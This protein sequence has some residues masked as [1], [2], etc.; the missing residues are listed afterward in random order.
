MS[1]VNGVDDGVGYGVSGRS[2]R[3]SGVGVYGDSS[4]GDGV[5]GWSSSGDGVRGYSYNRSG[6]IGYSYG[7]GVAGFSPGGFGVYG[8]SSIGYGVYGESNSS[9][10]VD[11]FSNS[12]YG[13]RGVSNS[14]AGVYGSSTGSGYAAYLDGRVYIRGP[15]EKPAGSFKIDH[16]LDP[17]NKYLSH[18]FV[19]SPDMK[20]VYDGVVILDDKGEAE[21][22]LPDWFGALNKDF[23]Y[24]LLLSG[25]LDQI[26]ILQRRYLMVLQTTVTAAIKTTKAA[27][28]LQEVPQV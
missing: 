12:S 23:R 27:S 26:S 17:A 25:L 7:N 11:G 4:S 21:I 8:S 20:N 6:V 19:E 15:L 24:Q 9:Y 2:N 22:E 5:R 1:S 10:G 14:G 16:P 28:R 3:F 13:V 18:S